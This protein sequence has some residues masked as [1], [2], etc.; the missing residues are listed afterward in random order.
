MNH[1][2][3]PLSYSIRFISHGTTGGL[4]TESASASSHN[5]YR[6]IEAACLGI[7]IGVASIEVYSTYSR[8]AK[9]QDLHELKQ[10]LHE[11][12]GEF[13]KKFDKLEAKLDSLLVIL[14]QPSYVHTQQLYKKA[15]E[16]EYRELR[17]KIEEFN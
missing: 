15:K 4:G 11:L 16:A 5:R 8:M 3:Q 7:I 12:G 2:L 6:F 1:R 10:D 17:R 13:Y 14:T 9:K